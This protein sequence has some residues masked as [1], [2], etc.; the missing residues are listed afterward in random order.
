MMILLA[1][2]LLMPPRTAE[3]F[4]GRQMAKTD[5]VN[6]AALI[7]PPP[8][9]SDDD[10]RHLYVICSDPGQDVDWY[11]FTCWNRNFTNVFVTRTAGCDFW[12]T[13]QF[14]RIY[15]SLTVS[16]DFGMAVSP[17]NGFYPPYDPDRMDIFVPGIS[18]FILQS[19]AD[20]KTWTASTVIDRAT[21][22]L[23]G[24]QNYYRVQGVTNALQCFAYNPLNKWP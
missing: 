4:S 16:N 18:K 6:P 10:I 13:N 11:I 2:V 21:V 9:E 24:R 23:S 7:P 5:A 1:I 8:E 15:A 3:T 20:R 17:R 22:P 19:S 12:I 14:D